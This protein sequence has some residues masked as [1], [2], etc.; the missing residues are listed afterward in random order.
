MTTDRIQTFKDLR[1]GPNAMYRL[2]PVQPL[3]FV[4]YLQH[5]YSSTTVLSALDTPQISEYTVV[6][7]L[8]CDVNFSISEL[9]F[10]KG[11]TNIDYFSLHCYLS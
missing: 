6:L 2:V 10:Y 4:P 9:K 3:L 5:T 1:V 8:P 11:R 7:S